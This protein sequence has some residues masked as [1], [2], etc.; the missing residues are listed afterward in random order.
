MSI[1]VNDYIKYDLYTIFLLTKENFSLSL[2]RK[3]YQRQILIYHPDKFESNISDDEKKE[4]YNTF[5]LIN[6]AYTILS[7]DTLRNQYNE[8]KLKL[9]QLDKQLDKSKLNINFSDSCYNKIIEYT[10]KNIDLKV[11]S[12]IRE[13]VRI[14]E[15]ILFIFVSILSTTN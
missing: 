1:S 12:G 11:S 6:S 5:N 14:L 13:S 15:K 8:E 10:D 4:K 7:N 9:G 3:A 2:L